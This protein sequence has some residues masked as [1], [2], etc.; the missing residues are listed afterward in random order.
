ME[1]RI[2]KILQI[3][4]IVNEIDYKRDDWTDYSR[5]KQ[6]LRG[7]MKSILSSITEQDLMS[8]RGNDF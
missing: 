3:A 2:K 1:E 8:A 6:D 4:S 5:L 7:S